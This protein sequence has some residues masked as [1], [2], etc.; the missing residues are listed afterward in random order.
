MRPD[1]GRQ[2]KWLGLEP[3]R[4][5]IAKIVS[6]YVKGNTVSQA[7][8]PALI[9][10]VGAF[11]YDLNKPIPLVAATPAVSARRSVLPDAVICLHCGW[12]GKMLRGH[13]SSA[14]GLSPSAYRDR[15]GLKASHP[16]VAPSYSKRRSALALSL[17]LGRRA[18]N[19]TRVSSDAGKKPSR[20]GRP[21]K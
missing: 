10:D 19:P 14:H 15:W 20:Q 16:L 5:H 3:M 8:L 13:I 9:A 7:E 17:G 12:R 11:L 1:Q 18:A 21:R 4:D 6:A 2:A